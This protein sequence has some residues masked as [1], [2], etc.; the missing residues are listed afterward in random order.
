M[1]PGAL[2]LIRSN[3][4]FVKSNGELESRVVS[5]YVLDQDAGGAI[6]GAG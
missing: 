2:A 3:F 6:K 5:R 4:P 1:P